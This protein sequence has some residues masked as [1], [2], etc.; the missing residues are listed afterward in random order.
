[1]YE[2]LRA[3]HPAAFDY[4]RRALDFN[5]AQIVTLASIVEKETGRPDERSRVAQVFLNRLLLPSFSPKLLQTDP[6]IVYGCTGAPLYQGK[7]SAACREWDGRIR[8]IHLEDRK[9][10]FNTYTHLGLPPGPIANPG[11]DALA[12]VLT[13]DGTPYLYF[14]ATNDGRHHFSTT[15]AEHE[16]AGVKYQRGGKPLAKATAK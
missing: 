12:A 14:V 11:R 9:N 4:L 10:E 7:A 13:P 1:V 6:T 15:I 5:D 16:L 8:R 3:A 2:E